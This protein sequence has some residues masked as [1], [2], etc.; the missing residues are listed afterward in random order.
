M[1]VFTFIA[2]S[3]LPQ[4][5]LGSLFGMNVNVPMADSSGTW[6]FW[7]IVGVTG[8][9]SIIAFLYFRHQKFI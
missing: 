8:F 6:A 4:T 9:F 2:V 3:F 5:V 7:A 1:K